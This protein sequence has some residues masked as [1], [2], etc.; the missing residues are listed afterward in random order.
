MPL[1]L[2]VGVVVGAAAASRKV[3]GAVRQGMVYGLAGVLKAYD[4]VSGIAHGAVKGARQGATGAAGADSPG[5]NG[6]GATAP[7]AATATAAST[8]S[9]P[10]GAPAT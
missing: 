5:T 2:L 4:K 7:A 9:S 6:P 3:R 1:D 10:V 8:P